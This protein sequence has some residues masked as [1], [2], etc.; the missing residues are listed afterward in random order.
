M[1][2]SPAVIQ[3]GS[4]SKDLTVHASMP[5]ISDAQKSVTATPL[6]LVLSAFF[7]IKSCFCMS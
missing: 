1:V 3:G 2:R 6:F 5:R 7:N 4:I